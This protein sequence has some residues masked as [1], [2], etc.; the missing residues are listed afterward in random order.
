MFAFLF[1]SGCDVKAM[2]AMS[3]DRAVTALDLD[4]GRPV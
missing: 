2:Q 3:E 1:T 4:T